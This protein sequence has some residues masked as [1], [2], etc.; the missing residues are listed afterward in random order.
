MDMATRSPSS[1]RVCS[2]LPSA[3]K[4][5]YQLGLQDQL[6]GVTSYCESDKPLVVRSSLDDTS[7]SASEIDTIVSRSKGSG[8]SLY[9]I[10]VPLLEEIA[11]DVI[12]V[13]DVCEICQVDSRYV[14]EVIKQ[15]S[16]TPTLVSLTPYSIEDIWKTVEQVG[17][18]MNAESVATSTIA[19]YKERISAIS[20]AIDQ[21]GRSPV[22]VFVMEWVDPIYNSGHW[23]PDQTRLAGGNDALAHPHRDSVALPLDKLLEYDPEYIIIAACGYD[24]HQTI[25]QYKK[26]A[27]M[28]SNEWANLSAVQ[29]NKVYTIDG[30]LFTCPSMEVVDGIEIMASILHPE[31]VLLPKTLSAHL[32]HIP[33]YDLLFS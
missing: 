4:I 13:Q 2:F 16:Y 14:Q 32:K 30:D 28:Q 5:I 15:L 3:T 7:L 21:A 19:K 24:V 23:I 1:V 25:D 27:M 10:D 8:T 12:F 9:Q 6:Y 29:N 11:P 17:E 33:A 18:V 22:S 31:A 26:S 20:S